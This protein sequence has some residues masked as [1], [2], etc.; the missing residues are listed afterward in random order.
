MDSTA[1]CCVW[2]FDEFEFV[3]TEEDAVGCWH[4]TVPE[5]DATAVDLLGIAIGSVAVVVA[6]EDRGTS[7]GSIRGPVGSELLL[8]IVVGRLARPVDEHQR[9]LCLKVNCCMTTSR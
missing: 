3:G 9:L 2:G 4:R 8:T 7:L 6:A 1:T 5:L